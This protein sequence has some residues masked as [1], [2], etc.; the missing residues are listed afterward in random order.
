M[1]ATKKKKRFEEERLKRGTCVFLVCYSNSSSFFILRFHLFDLFDM[2]WTQFQCLPNC[3]LNYSAAWLFRS[4]RCANERSYLV[5]ANKRIE[6]F[7]KDGRNRWRRSRSTA[8]PRCLCVC[9]KFINVMINNGHGN[10]HAVWFNC[11]KW[12]GSLFIHCAIARSQPGA[13][14]GNRIAEKK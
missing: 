6:L 2:K 8:G 7:R 11:L 1:T 14:N 9:D 3:S 12:R 10:R 4:N 5:H 13:S